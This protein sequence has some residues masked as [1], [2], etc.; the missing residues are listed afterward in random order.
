MTAPDIG[1]DLTEDVCPYCDTVFLFARGHYCELAPAFERHGE[2]V[3]NMRWQGERLYCCTAS[4]TRLVVNVAYPNATWANVSL[5]TVAGVEWTVFVI[6][7]RIY[8]AIVNRLTPPPPGFIGPR[9]EPTHVSTLLP[10]WG[11]SVYDRPYS[12]L[13]AVKSWRVDITDPSVHQY[14]GIGFRIPLVSR[15]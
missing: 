4:R 15:P 9:Q 13:G 8:T 1:Y 12:H 11:L 6:P 2:R 7:V 5:V 3:V 14:P 10:R